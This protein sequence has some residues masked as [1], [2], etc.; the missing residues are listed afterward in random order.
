[1]TDY[2]KHS[3]KLHK[4]LKRNYKGASNCVYKMIISYFV[5]VLVLVLVHRSIFVMDSSRD[6]RLMKIQQKE[7][8]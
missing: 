8:I 3:L 5:L 6:P 1:M 7:I 4:K 2:T